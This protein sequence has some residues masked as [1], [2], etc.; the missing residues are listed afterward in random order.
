MWNLPQKVEERIA[1][2]EQEI[3]NKVDEKRVNELIAM[4][5][6][7]KNLTSAQTDRTITTN[8]V[9]EVIQNQVKEQNLESKE[10]KD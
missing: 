8:A 2:L 6:L 4:A 1:R 7:E 5:K 9:K 10:R 3:K